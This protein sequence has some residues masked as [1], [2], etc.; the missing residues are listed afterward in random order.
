LSIELGHSA[1]G[2]RPTRWVKSEVVR[3]GV[4]QET[5]SAGV[6]K[7]GGNFPYTECR[8]CLSKVRRLSLWFGV[9]VKGFWL[10]AAS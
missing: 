8:H 4:L 7:K 2:D 3:G 5:K 6:K 9:M 10:L 1:N